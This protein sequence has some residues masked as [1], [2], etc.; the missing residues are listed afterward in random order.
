TTAEQLLSLAASAEQHSEHPI[1]RAIVAH[2]RARNIPLVA[3][4]GFGNEPGRGVR[5]TLDGAQYLVGH[6]EFASP[7]APIARSDTGPSTRVYGPRVGPDGTPH[8]LGSVALSDEI[9]PDSAAAIAALHA[10]G[11]RTVLLTGDNEATGRAVANAVGI[12]DVRA[13]VRPAQKAEA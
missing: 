6:P 8:V 7:G 13:D 5:A 3:L 2:A 1:A 12:D 11:L 9:N 10:A 4:G